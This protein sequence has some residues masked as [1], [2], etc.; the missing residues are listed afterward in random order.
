MAELANDNKAA[1]VPLVL[2][3]QNWAAHTRHLTQLKSQGLPAYK[4]IFNNILL[5]TIFGMCVIIDFHLI[6]PLLTITRL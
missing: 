1:M 6:P 4:Q 2:E 5:S 3:P